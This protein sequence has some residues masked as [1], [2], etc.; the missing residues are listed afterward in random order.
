L[1]QVVD[2]SVETVSSEMLLHKSQSFIRQINT[3]ANWISLKYFFLLLECQ[4]TNHEPLTAIAPP[5]F[6]FIPYLCIWHH[7]KWTW[8]SKG[9]GSLLKY[10]IRTI[11]GRHG[12]PLRVHT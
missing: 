2:S 7:K 11:V 12:L 5:L 8:S 6:Q 4:E 10:P 1:K 9:G 3:H